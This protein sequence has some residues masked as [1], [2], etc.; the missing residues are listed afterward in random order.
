MNLSSLISTLIDNLNNMYAEEG[1]YKFWT[2][3]VVDDRH[4]LF[5]HFELDIVKDE[6]VNLKWFSV[7]NVNIFFNVLKSNYEKDGG[8]NE[9]NSIVNWT[10]FEQTIE[11]WRM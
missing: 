2:L 10:G 11:A 6:I 7:R 1:T 3:S 8:D 5:S 9:Y 4:L